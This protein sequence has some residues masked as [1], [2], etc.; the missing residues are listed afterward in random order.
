M[1]NGEIAE[2]DA[3]KLLRVGTLQMS[4]MSCVQSRD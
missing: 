4:Q 3:P 1:D 2:I